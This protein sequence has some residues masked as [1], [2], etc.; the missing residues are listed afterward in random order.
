LAI[1]LLSMTHRLARPARP[2]PPSIKS[3]RKIGG[4]A[5]GIRNSEAGSGG[6][7]S[8]A[9]GSSEMF[10]ASMIFSEQPGN[11]HW[12]PD[13]ANSFLIVDLDGSAK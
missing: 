2:P 4:A 12:F 10:D 5:V 8:R 9:C 7:V 1:G 3:K 13:N 6:A 11:A